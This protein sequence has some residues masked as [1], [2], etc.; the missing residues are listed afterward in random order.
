M[1]KALTSTTGPRRSTAIQWTDCTD[2]II[3]GL[4]GGWWCQKCSPGCKNCYAEKLN[5]S[6]Y[7]KGNHLPYTGKPPHLKLRRDIIEG[8]ARQRVPRKHFVASMTDVFGEWVPQEW[9]FTM[10]DGMRN[11]PKQTFQVLTKRASMMASQ[12]LEWLQMRGLARVP[13]NIW[14]GF[15]AENQHWFD[16]RAKYAAMLR[17]VCDV[18]WVS[19]EPLLGPLMPVF[20]GFRPDWIVLGGESGKDAR[21]CQVQWIRSNV[22][23]ARALGMAVFVKQLGGNLSDHDLDWCDRESGR[24]MHHPKGG[25]MHEWPECLRVREFP[26]VP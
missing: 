24:S 6:A 25:D 5:D 21:I 22:N 14:L 17:G 9:I 15:S 7:F 26:A 4:D 11:A 2:N 20:D 18:L 12:V 13:S 16:A 1:T 19:A 3:V 8:W 10:L 23:G